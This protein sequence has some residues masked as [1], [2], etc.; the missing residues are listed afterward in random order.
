MLSVRCSGEIEAQPKKFSHTELDASQGQKKLQVQCLS[1]LAQGAQMH[2]VQHVCT[3]AQKWS[4]AKRQY[5]DMAVGFWV[6][7][8]VMCS[9]RMHVLYSPS[10]WLHEER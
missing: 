1:H 8:Q 4:Q 5:C 6:K 10:Q 7:K 9:E 2:G 3:R